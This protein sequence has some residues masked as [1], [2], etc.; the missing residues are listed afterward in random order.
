MKEIVKKKKTFSHTGSWTRAA[1][2]KTG[3]PNRW[4]MWEFVECIIGESILGHDFAWC[5]CCVF[6]VFS[7]MLFFFAS[8]A[9]YFSVRAV[10]MWP[11]Y[12]F[13][14]SFI[15]IVT[16]ACV[17]GGFFYFFFRAKEEISRTREGRKGEEPP[18]PFVPLA[19]PVKRH[20]C[21]YFAG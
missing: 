17:A 21:A 19:R 1:W 9:E 18:L 4:T 6:A 10:L 14:S 15:E 16:Q 13:D 5:L 20:D 7:E 8:I 3:N 2:V 12:Q 11:S